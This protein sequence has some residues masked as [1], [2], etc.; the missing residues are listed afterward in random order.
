MQPLDCMAGAMSANDMYDKS[1]P[2][3]RDLDLQK[4]TSY[5]SLLK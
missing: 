2:R 4:M 5:Y 3:Y 1:V